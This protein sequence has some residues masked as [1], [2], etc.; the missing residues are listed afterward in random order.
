MTTPS[1]PAPGSPAPTAPPA[2]KRTRKADRYTDIFLILTAFFGAWGVAL[3]VLT[4]LAI[5]TPAFLYSDQKNLLKALGSTVV[6]LLAIS[7]AVSMNMAMGLIPRGSVRM[8]TLM[9]THRYGGR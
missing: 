9:R 6:G 4:S 8:R 5:T 2:V 3:F 1:I 7:Q